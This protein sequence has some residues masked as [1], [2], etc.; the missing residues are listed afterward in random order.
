MIGSALAVKI[1][2]SLGEIG[3]TC[4]KN[5]KRRLVKIDPI[6]K[7]MKMLVYTK[8]ITLK[9]FKTLIMGKIML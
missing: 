8:K 5:Q 3:A 4:V 1:I 9:W 2:T 6:L 7:I